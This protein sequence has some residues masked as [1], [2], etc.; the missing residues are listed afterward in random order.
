MSYVR[1]H[2]ILLFCANMRTEQAREKKKLLV[3]RREQIIGLAHMR[4]VDRKKRRKRKKKGE[5]DTKLHLF[6]D[7]RK[8]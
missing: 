5:A 1:E 4:F 7:R 3:V 6:I 2:A 8:T